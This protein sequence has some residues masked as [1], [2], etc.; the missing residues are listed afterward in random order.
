MA[1]VLK[2]RL[3]SGLFGI[4]LVCAV[5]AMS[6]KAVRVGEAMDLLVGLI[7]RGP[8]L[9][10]RARCMRCPKLQR[11]AREATKI[12]RRFES[13]PTN[14]HNMGMGQYL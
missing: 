3:S 14:R 1:F 4:L 8:S 11:R 13:A 5:C 7:P 2:N 9:A 10:P 12:Q 6:C